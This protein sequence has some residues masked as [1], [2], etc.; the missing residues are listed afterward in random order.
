MPCSSQLP[1]YVDH[2]FGFF[3]SPYL[4]R[5]PLPHISTR[6]Q[7]NDNASCFCEYLG[8]AK[9]AGSS[10]TQVDRHLKTFHY[11]GMVIRFRD[12][13]TWVHIISMHKSRAGL[14]ETET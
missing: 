14:A 10:L 1:Y 5:C 12:V 3:F 6:R 7:Q 8:K 9:K 2:F 11:L 4:P 13:A